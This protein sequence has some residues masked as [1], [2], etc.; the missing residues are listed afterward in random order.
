MRLAGIRLPG[1]VAHVLTPEA[2]ATVQVAG[3]YSGPEYDE[4]SPVLQAASGSE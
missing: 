1:N 2:L 3:S 4:K